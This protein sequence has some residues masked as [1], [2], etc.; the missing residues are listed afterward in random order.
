MLLDVARCDGEQE[1]V[2]LGH[3]LELIELL[4]LR[5]E[6][7]AILRKELKLGARELKLLKERA[8]AGLARMKDVGEESLQADRP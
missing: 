2:P 4:E 7:E 1:E 6:F 3:V 8:M 5:T